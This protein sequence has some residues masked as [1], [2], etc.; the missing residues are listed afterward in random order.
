MNHKVGMISLGCPKNLVDGEMMLA[1][2]RQ[3]G[4]QIVTD[5]DE[6]DAIIVNTCGFIE[7]AKKEA[8]DNILEMAQ[9]K[10]EGTIRAVVVTGCLAERYREEV[11]KE[12]PEV[13]AVIGIGKNADIAQVVTDALAGTQTEAFPPKDR[14]CM[15][16]ERV[17]ATPPFW[18]YLRIADGCDNRCSYC[19][20][21]MIRGR[22]RSRPMEEIL[23]EAKTLVKNGAKELILIAQDTTRYGE[24]LYGE[25][26]LPLLLRELC[27]IDGLSWLRLLYCYPDRITDEL[28]SVMAQEEKVLPYLDLPLQHADSAIL[29]A[30]NRTGDRRSLTKLIQHIRK[31]VPDV[32]LRTTLIVG[33]PGEGGKEFATLAQFIKD[34]RFDH[35]GC[36]TYSPEEGTPA[37]AMGSQVPEDVKQRRQEIIMEEQSRIVERRLKSKKGKTM[38]VLVEGFD[39][40]A[41]CWYG[42]TAA[43]APD[44]DG[45]VFFHVK[46]PVSPGDLLPVTVTGYLD[47]DLVGEE[48]EDGPRKS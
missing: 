47:Y 42:R 44:I 33:F 35:L 28:L 26:R 34:V 21:P 18:A 27:K 9:L 30:M 15:N 36:F 41:E 19:A 31:T 12:I 25:L 24:D 8:I 43:D 45:K 29:R 7:D 22:F 37:A 32:T 40:Y 39:A 23:E 4:F 13:D 38:P 17:L 6:A 11:K 1:K 48:A 46:A 14:L 16:G 3:A 20:I 5:V 2:L 10:Q